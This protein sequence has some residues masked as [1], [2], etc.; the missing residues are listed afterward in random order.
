[1]IFN[2]LNRLIRLIKREMKQ[3]IKLGFLIEFNQL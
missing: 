3:F 1:M 2:G